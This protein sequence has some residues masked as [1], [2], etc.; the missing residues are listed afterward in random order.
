MKRNVWGCLPAAVLALALTGC[1]QGDDRTTAAPQTVTQTATRTVTSTSTETTAVES[2]PVVEEPVED[3]TE[4]ESTT[5]SDDA[6]V[7]EDPDRPDDAMSVG[8]SGTL[9]GLDVTVEKFE[10]VEVVDPLDGYTYYGALVK[11]VN[12]SG[13]PA[14]IVPG[15]QM[16][17][18]NIYVATVEPLIEE[19]VE[20]EALPAFETMRPNAT[21]NG[22]LVWAIPDT[23]ELM[24]SFGIYFEDFLG[25][26][27]MVWWNNIP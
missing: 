11:I 18:E 21:M 14:E 26:D 1:G 9:D 19:L 24:K 16:R 27:E 4:S 10:V 7:R 2:S 17:L 3:E 22:W 12:S 5:E 8:D 20:G 23:S 25:L 15:A 6:T 13:G